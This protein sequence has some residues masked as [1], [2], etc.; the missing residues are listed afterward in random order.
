MLQFDCNVDAFEPNVIHFWER[1]QSFT[2]MND[3]RASPEHCGFMN[4]VSRAG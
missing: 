4:E 3:I 1:Y 2:T